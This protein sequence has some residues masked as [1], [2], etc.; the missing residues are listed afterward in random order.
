MMVETYLLD[1][2]TNL[3]FQIQTDIPPHLLLVLVFSKAMPI[4]NFSYT[5]MVRMVKFMLMIGLALRLGLTATSLIMMQFLQQRD[6][7]MDLL[8]T[9][10]S[11]RKDILMLLI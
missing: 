6:L 8:H 2:L 5:L 10:V 4:Q 1:I 3:E 11:K 7:L 9:I